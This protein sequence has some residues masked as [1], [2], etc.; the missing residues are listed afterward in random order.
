VLEE[1]ILQELDLDA[2]DTVRIR[3]DAEYLTDD[4]WLQD[5][6]EVAV[7]QVDGETRERLVLLDAQRG[8]GLPDFAQHL[9][10]RLRAPVLSMD[11][12][13]E[14]DYGGNIEVTPDQILF[15]GD[16]TSAELQDYLEGYGY[17]DSTIVLQTSHLVVGHVDELVTFTWS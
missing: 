4:L 2:S 3:V 7:Y 11:V 1:G 13:S 8:R 9:G 16:T 14:G 17:A 5:W 15:L 10:R 6:G 12:A